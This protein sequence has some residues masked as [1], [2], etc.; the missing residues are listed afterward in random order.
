MNL[1]IFWLFGLP[2]IV[3]PRVSNTYLIGNVFRPV[4]I[5]FILLSHVIYMSPYVLCVAL[6]LPVSYNFNYI[7]CF[8]LSSVTKQFCRYAGFILVF[9]L[10]L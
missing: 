5:I 6:V 10:Y 4:C 9:N 1:P 8:T 7:C 3:G 2:T